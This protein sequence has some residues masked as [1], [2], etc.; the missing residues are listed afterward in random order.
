MRAADYCQTQG[1]LLFGLD[2]GRVG[3]TRALLGGF[4]LDAAEFFCVG[5]DK[6]H[7]LVEC[8]HLAGHLTA[9][10]QSDAHSVVDEILHLPLLVGRHGGQRCARMRLEEFQRMRTLT[11]AGH[12]R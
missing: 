8:E 4:S 12:R 2:E 6:V 11:P 3:G 5:E 7:V 9:I 10:G 1:P